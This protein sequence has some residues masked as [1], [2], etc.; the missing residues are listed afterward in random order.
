MFANNIHRPGLGLGVGLGSLFAGVA[1][2]LLFF[3]REHVSGRVRVEKS[4]L[5]RYRTYAGLSASWAEW[6]EWPFDTI[7]ACRFVSADALGQSFS[8]M[9]LATAD[10]REI[11]GIPDSVNLAKLKQHFASRNITVKESKGLP[12][13]FASRLPVAVA[14]AA[15]LIGLAVLIGGLMFFQNV[16]G[17]LIANAPAPVQF[18][19][20]QAPVMEAAPQQFNA[21]PLTNTPAAQPTVPDQPDSGQQRIAE[22]GA[23][24]GF[25][26]ARVDPAKKSVIGFQSTFG[27]WAGKPWVGRMDPI[28]EAEPALPNSQM[29][30]AKPGYAVGGLQ[31]DTPEFVNA[32]AVIFMRVKPDGRLDPTDSYISDWVGPK[33]DMPPQILSGQGKRVIG[34]HGRAGAILNAVGLVLAEE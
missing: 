24:G 20:P 29:T 18:H 10:E 30:T 11:V 19:H 34:I 22:V 17:N 6:Q 21:A 13:E 12:P 27:Q 33:S 28:Y 14:V 32:F 4:G 7:T 9:L 3:R 26:F 16:R 15:P 1:G 23:A 5:L 31:V 8:I 25:A 2:V